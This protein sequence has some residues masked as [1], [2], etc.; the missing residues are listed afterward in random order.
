MDKFRIHSESATLLIIDLQEK[1]MP[2][3]KDN[4]KVIKNTKILLALAKEYDMPV[5]V[6]EQYPR[7]LGATINEIKEELPDHYYYLD[8]MTFSAWGQEMQ[9][10]LK[11]IGTKGSQTIIVVGCE[12]HV[13]VFQTV[14]DLL[15]R[16]YNIHVV[17]DGVCSRFEENYENGLALMHDMGAVINNTETIVFDCLFRAE[18]ASFKVMSA[19]IK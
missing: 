16:G 8:K 17:R 19:Q 11:T 2:A 7:G 12:T 18:G 3:M 1:L 15:A 13:C 6:T 10:A 4:D 9:E 5:I 14:R